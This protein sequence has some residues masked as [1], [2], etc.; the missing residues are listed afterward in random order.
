MKGFRLNEDQE[1]VAKIMSAL[2]KAAGHC[3]CRMSKD[4]TTLCPCDDFVDSGLCKCKLFVE[5]SIKDEK[6]S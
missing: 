2:H 5:R 1:H 4:E 3:P 6:K